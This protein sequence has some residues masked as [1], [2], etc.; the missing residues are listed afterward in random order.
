MRLERQSNG[1][2]IT[3]DPASPLGFGGE[4]R[5][6]AVLSDARLAAKIYH[7]PT[8]E[9]ARKLGVMLANPPEDPTAA[10]EQLAIAWPLDLLRTPDVRKRVVGY[11]MPR[12]TGM[13][14]IF[15]F[16]N[17]L[18]RRQQHPLC[19]YLYLH[20][21]ARNL[22]AAVRALHARGYVIG[23]LNESNILVTETALVTLVDTDSFQVRDPQNGVLF[24]CPV[25]KPEFT[26]PELQ[27][28][29][30]LQID[31]VPEHDLFG[32]A[33]LL[34]QLLME[35]THPFAGVYQGAG[36]PPSYDA[37]ILAGHFPYGAR[38][39]PY[40]PMPTAPAV[41]ILHPTVRQLFSRCFEDGHAN[42]SARPD[43][44][45]W[46]SVLA[47]A[48]AA[49]VC[50]PANAQHRYGNHLPTCPWCARAA[51]LGG[52]DPFPSLEAVR[53][54]QHLPPTA[55]RT[56]APPRPR[57]PQPG[58]ARTFPAAPASGSG[59]GTAAYTS[60]A[61]LALFF[62]PG[63]NWTW[64][65]LVGVALAFLPGMHLL[66]ALAATVCGTVGCRSAAR[67][68][69]GERWTAWMALG[70]GSLTLVAALAANRLHAPNASGALTM[71]THHAP[72]LTVTFLPHRAT[73]ATGNSR[74]ED[75]A[76]LGGE[77]DLWNAQTGDMERSLAGF[78][79][80]VVSL[81]FSPDGRMLAA[82]TSAPLGTSE[83]RLWQVGTWEVWPS[84][85][86]NR[87]SV[88]AVAFSPDGRTI[89]VAGWQEAERRRIYGVIDLWDAQTRT[90]T[91]TLTTQGEVF[92]LAFS[93][94]GTLLA[95]G[96]GSSSGTSV[97]GRVDVWDLRTGRPKW[98]QTAHSTRVM[99]VTF[100]PD[101]TR[102]ASAGNDN[103]VRLWDVAT[104]RMQG[105]S[106][107]GEGDWVA[108][109]A[110][111]PDG[112]T[113]ASG[114]SDQVVR[115][116]DVASGQLQRVL[117]GP[118]AAINTLAYASDGRTLACGS[119][120]GKITVWRVK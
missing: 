55:R 107:E 34:F 90:L 25:G 117:R 31:R 95:T 1:Q 14:P 64:A 33:V 113:L 68:A 9:Y 84:L 6:Y 86:D 82:G 106:L 62:L 74:A 93:P 69:P 22:A 15:D 29:T 43:A 13:S 101:G 100:S 39:V 118:S 28:Q 38:R 17:P 88:H 61:P 19:S 45:T 67:A 18:A 27:G 44:N 85:T 71:G 81:A 49:L 46:Q 41:E 109:V 5:I 10:S 2:R 72:V 116:W 56:I 60:S 12:V 37:R 36:D 52:R 102:L 4:A 96:S 73:L 23:D 21:I 59:H 77:I 105:K 83:V 70:L 78:S 66:A 42:P 35:G 51:R 114:G 57:T 24:R 98:T 94:D 20:R 7:K 112:K 63:N 11:L 3:L 99:S 115:L 76:M 87:F 120:D 53:S 79:G 58:A 54:G 97:L 26:P 75:E 16:Y 65:A 110:F 40:R 80:D 30:F 50:C 119:Q 89:A 47:E 48:E 32:L 104:G 91:Q 103:A 108:S 111:S 8:E 92:T